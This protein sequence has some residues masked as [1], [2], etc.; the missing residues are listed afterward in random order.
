MSSEIRPNLRSR[1]AYAAAARDWCFLNPAFAPSRVR[2]SDVDGI[3]ERHGHFLVLE[4]K[5]SRSGLSEGQA[6]L[7]RELSDLGFLVLVVW[8]PA[9][10]IFWAQIVGFTQRMNATD[11]TVCRI[12][13]A[14]FGEAN[15]GRKENGINARQAALDEWMWIYG[16]H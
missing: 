16:S 7:L 8:G 9:E 3:V 4:S 13:E 15:R 2:V 11:K 12:V 1:D 5:P 6:I 10:E 14:W